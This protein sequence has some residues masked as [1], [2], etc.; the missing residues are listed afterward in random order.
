MNGFIAMMHWELGLEAKQDC[1]DAYIRPLTFF[2]LFRH[3]TFLLTV[4]DSVLGVWT[5]IVYK[6]TEFESSVKT[7]FLVTIWVHTHDPPFIMGLSLPT[8][9]WGHGA[10]CEMHLFRCRYYDWRGL[11]L[12]DPANLGSLLLLSVFC[13]CLLLIE[14]LCLYSECP[15]FVFCAIF[16]L[17]CLFEFNCAVGLM[18]CGS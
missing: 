13:C 11:R 5:Q 6:N 12:S 15:R 7:P 10:Q 2:G 17:F 18:L 16:L 4:L 9:V 3:P 14:A 8:G 1:S